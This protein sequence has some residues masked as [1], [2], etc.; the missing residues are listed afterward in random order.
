MK[1]KAIPPPMIMASTS[2]Q[3]DMLSCFHYWLTLGN[4]ET[5][6]SKVQI[7]TREHT[8]PRLV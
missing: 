4:L 2:W 1:V 8:L 7:R 6:T 3:T 5:E